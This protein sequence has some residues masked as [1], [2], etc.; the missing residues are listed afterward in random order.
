MKV[1]MN[2]PRVEEEKKT[3]YLTSIFEY[4]NINIQFRAKIDDTTNQ[5]RGDIKWR[6]IK[7]IQIRL[8]H[9]FSFLSH[10]KLCLVEVQI[11]VLFSKSDFD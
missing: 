3:S 10:V 5:D 6:L 8:V 4:I 9:T 1:I 7:N 2:N 11:F